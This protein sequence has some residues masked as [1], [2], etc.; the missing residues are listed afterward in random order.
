MA[1]KFYNTDERKGF[2]KKVFFELVA[3]LAQG[4]DLEDEELDNVYE[5]AQH[6]LE[7]IANRP[8]ANG[9]KKDPLQSDYANHIRQSILPL[10]T[11]DPKTAK[12]L[13]AM[14]T[15]NGIVA[16]NTG[17]ELSAP[18][19]S[20]VLNSEPGIVK[21]AKVVEKVDSKGLKSQT[22]AAAYI[23]G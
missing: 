3:A 21:V 23:R 18:W 14:A 10:V 5:A 9:D 2:T 13:V 22:E 4:E 19:V 11:N 6:E 7:M 1:N 17:K 8:K 15:A 20:R 16:P 12:E